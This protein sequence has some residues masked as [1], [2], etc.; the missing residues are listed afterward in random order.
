MEVEQF[1]TP[2]ESA[3]SQPQPTTPATMKG[4]STQSST[5]L[6]K[7]AEALTQVISKHNLHDQTK[8]A[9]NEILELVKKENLKDERERTYVPILAVK[10]IHEQFKANLGHV[11]ESIE[12]KLSNLQAAPKR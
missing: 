6:H 10:T 7:V 4:K 1:P 9:L 5:Q 11:Q 3:Q 2:A 8:M 12:T